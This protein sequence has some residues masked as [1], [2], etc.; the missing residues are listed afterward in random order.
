[1]LHLLCTAASAKPSIID[2]ELVKVL[3]SKG[4]DPR[5]R[6][7][8]GELPMQLL[9][10]QPRHPAEVHQHGPYIPGDGIE[11]LRLMYKLLTSLR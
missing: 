7:E 2:N 4:A 6:N 10:P 9:I 5:Q 11:K 3:L 8:E 1:M